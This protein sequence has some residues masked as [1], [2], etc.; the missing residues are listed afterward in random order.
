MTNIPF[1]TAPAFRHPTIAHGFFTREG[2]ASE[3]IYTSLNVGIGSKDD[4]HRVLE[5][6]KRVREALGAQH[7]N[8]LYQIHSAEVEIVTAPWPQDAQPKADA[9]VTKLPGI[10]LGILT[11][12]CGPVLFADAKNGVI[13]AVH[14]GWKGAFGGVL[15]NT[16]AAMEALGAERMHIT[17]VLGP[18]IAQDSYEIGPEFRERLVAAKPGNTAY[19]IPSIKPGHFMF[20]LPGYI[21]S[22]LEP[23]GLAKVELLARDTCAEEKHFFSYRRSCLRN[24]PDY[25]RQVSAIMLR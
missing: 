8:C 5:N 14:A 22:R 3:G 7:L 24:E 9:M 13:G 17:A 12:D 16:V 23:L 19:F 4:R 21:A 11:A 15:E 20:D 2:G 25:G 1:L 18:C 10:A 6:R